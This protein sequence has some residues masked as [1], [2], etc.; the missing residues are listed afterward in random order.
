AQLAPDEAAERVVAGAGDD[1]RP[2]AVAGRGDGDVRRGTAEILGE[3]LHLLEA[4]AGLEWIDVNADPAHRDDVEVRG[5]GRGLGRLRDRSVAR[6]H[7]TRSRAWSSSC[8]S[9]S[10][11]APPAISKA[12]SSRLV[13]ALVRSPGLLPRLRTRKR[14]PT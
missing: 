6:G 4:H 12:R 10:S 13:S 7:A 11:S 8:A 2:P 1:R 3:R 14:S 5:G 9:S